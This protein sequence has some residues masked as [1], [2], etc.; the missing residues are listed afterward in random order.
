[1]VENISL[2]SDDPTY[3]IFVANVIKNTGWTY[4]EFLIAPQWLLETFNIMARIDKDK[5][6][7]NS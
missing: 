7:K 3:E 5:S 2:S 4:E 6:Q 1:M